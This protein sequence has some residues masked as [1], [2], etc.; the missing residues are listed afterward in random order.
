MKIHSI[1]NLRKNRSYLDIYWDGSLKIKKNRAEVYRADICYRKN[2]FYI[3]ICKENSIFV[4]LAD[5]L[6]LF[7]SF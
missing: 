7:D 2:I 3:K 5:I 1:M 4:F 6:L